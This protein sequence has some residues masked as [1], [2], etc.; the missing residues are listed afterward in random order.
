MED[1]PRQR[2]DVYVGTKL[3]DVSR[4]SISDLIHNGKVVVNGQP[5]TKKSYIVKSNDKIKIINSLKSHKIRSLNL[6]VIY[7]D[8]DV[9]VINKPPG[10]LT[11]TKGQQ[12]NE[13]TIA[14][15]IKDKLKGLDGNRAGIVHRLD[16][17]TSGLIIG[18]KNP[19][20]LAWLQK[21]FSTRKVKKTYFALAEGTLKTKQAII[22]MPIERN[23]KRPQT[24]RVGA[25]GKKAITEYEVIKETGK[26]SLIM[27]YPKT[28]R[29]HQ[30]RVHMV[31][32]GHPIFGDSLYG[33]TPSDRMYLHAAELELT[34]P[35]KERRKFESPLP[36][37]FNKLLAND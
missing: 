19:E 32:L 5:Q 16:R 20:A 2:L 27:L 21:Q 3:K 25:N 7:E 17:A 13:A 15:F 24:F 30:L 34:L 29:T 18:A 14:S 8:K 11:H 22:D 36:K 1:T 12:S 31:A 23:P 28:G 10:L 6:E 26:L 37:E 33:N 4:K 35:S 9:I